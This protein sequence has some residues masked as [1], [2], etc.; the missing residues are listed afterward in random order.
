MAC[1]QTVFDRPSVAGAVLQTATSLNQDRSKHQEV[2]STPAKKL[3]KL[4]VE[5]WGPYWCK[6]KVYPER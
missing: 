1:V 4:I 3:T 6:N 2:G 5:F